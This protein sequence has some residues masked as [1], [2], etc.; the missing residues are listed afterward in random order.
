MANQE[1]DRNLAM[2][3]ARVTEAAAMA[4]GRWMG[5]GDREAS[6]QAAMNATRLVLDSVEMDGVVVIGEGDEGQVAHLFNGQ[7]LGT[8]H[9]PQG[10]YCRRRDRRHER[11]GPGPL[12]CAVGGRPL[13]AGHHVRSAGDAVHGKVAVGPDAAGSVYR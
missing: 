1:P 5:R 9:Q 8:G 4:A 11:A 12:G 6:D 13:G 3:L 10:G 2:E 7:A